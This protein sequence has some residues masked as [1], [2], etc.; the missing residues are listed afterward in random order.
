MCKTTNL[1]REKGLRKK[2]E[3]DTTFSNSFVYQV[4]TT[5]PSK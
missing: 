1:R 5:L 4:T 3:K 2:K